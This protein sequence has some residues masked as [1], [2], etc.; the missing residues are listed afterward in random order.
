M[1]LDRSELGPRWIDH[2][3]AVNGLVLGV[4]YMNR[5]TPTYINNPFSVNGSLI[6]LSIDDVSVRVCPHF[7]FSTIENGSFKIPWE[8]ISVCLP[9]F[10]PIN[11]NCALRYWSNIFGFLRCL[12]VFITTLAL[13]ARIQGLGTFLGC[14]YS[15]TA[16]KSQ[17]KAK[18]WTEKL[19]EIKV[20]K[21]FVRFVGYIVFLHFHIFY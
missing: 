10:G 19:N 6:A 1:N 13:H 17:L 11:S 21:Y 3:A 8:S 12:L 7:A 5:A 4:V 2:S 18:L 20:M 15:I 16:L 9:H 14:V